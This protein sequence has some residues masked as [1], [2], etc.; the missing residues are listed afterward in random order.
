MR[1][2]GGCLCIAIL[3]LSLEK[4]SAV[5]E[6]RSRCIDTPKVA[7]EIFRSSTWF[8]ANVTP[9][10][11]IWI[12]TSKLVPDADEASI[13]SMPLLCDAMADRYASFVNAVRKNA[14]VC[15]IKIH[16]QEI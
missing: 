15:N 11:N 8:A 4:Y 16:C 7:G 6:Y 13:L 5:I 12:R 9:L 14:S 2:P 3:M 1:F 10:E